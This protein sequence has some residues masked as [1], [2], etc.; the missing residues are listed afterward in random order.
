MHNYLVE[1]GKGPIAVFAK[2]QIDRQIG[3]K[4]IQI[5]IDVSI[6]KYIGC[7]RVP[8][9]VLL[10]ASRFLTTL[11]PCSNSFLLQFFLWVGS[12]IFYFYLFNF[13]VSKY[14]EIFQLSF[15]YQFLMYSHCGQRTYF[16]F[17]I[18]IILNLLRLILWLKILFNSFF[19][20]VH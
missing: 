5:D 1:N 17:I 8:I 18:G 2:Y 10:L 12:H 13:L 9:Q 3:W 19:I 6:Y 20:T 16:F 15:C 4:Y 11:A 14:L 7:Y